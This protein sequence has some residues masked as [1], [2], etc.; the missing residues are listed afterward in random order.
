[1]EHHPDPKE[2]LTIN[3]RRA[4][5]L[6]FGVEENELQIVPVGGGYSRN[7]RALAGSGGDWV[8]VKEVDTDLLPD[9]GEEEL[10]WLRKDLLC[11]ETLRSKGSIVV[12][13]ESSL[14]E[15]GH[16][17]MMTAYRKEEGW[18]WYPPKDREQQVTY[19]NSVI[20]AIHSLE[21]ISFTPQ[22]AELLR[23][24]PVFR[25]ELALDEGIDL[26]LQNESIR[27]QLID[28]YR[29]YASDHG[30]RLAPELSEMTTLLQ[31]ESRLRQ[32]KSIA[33]QL[34]DQPNDCFGHCDVRSDNVAV[35][36]KTGEVKFVDWNWASYATK[37]FGAT[38][39]L[40]DMYRH[41][42]NIDPWLDELNPQ[43]LAAL[44]GFYARR[45]LKDPLTP[46]STLRRMQAESAAIA[47]ALW[48]RVTST[49]SDRTAAVHS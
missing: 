35:N 6:H 13:A 25:D 1:M 46:G 21:N 31:D 22:E 37:G 24:A 45:C 18:L 34:L 26:I 2:L 17:L 10:W 11:T 29:L 42:I 20:S 49:K 41:G 23:L 16:V 38:E 36:S 39:F 44:V 43:M 9:D 8:F 4:A 28:R 15:S 19:I 12:P 33:A 40:T 7:R 27:E 32:L 3:A 5:L 47:Y 30:G 14:D 48:L